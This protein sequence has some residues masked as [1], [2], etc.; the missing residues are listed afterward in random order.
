MASPSITRAS[1]LLGSLASTFL[2]CSSAATE[3]LAC[4]AA[5]AE[6]MWSPGDLLH[7]A[8]CKHSGS[9]SP[10]ITTRWNGFIAKAAPKILLGLQLESVAHSNPAPASAG[11]L[12]ACKSAAYRDFLH[13]S[14]RS[15]P[16]RPSPWTKAC[17]ACPRGTDWPDADANSTARSILE[18]EKSSED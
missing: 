13:V 7:P 17:N 10:K 14:C 9:P 12:F 6:A 8:K 15:T 16:V 18:R 1:V 4:I 5:L 2:R 3:S 11:P